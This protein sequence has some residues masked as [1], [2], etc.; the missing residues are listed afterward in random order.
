MEDRETIEKELWDRYNRRFKSKP[1]RKYKEYAIITPESAT[2][3][4]LAIWWTSM[5]VLLIKIL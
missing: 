2:L 3:L 5:V 4:L 1:A